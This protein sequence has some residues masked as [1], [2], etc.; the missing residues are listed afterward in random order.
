MEINSSINILGSIKDLELVIHFLIGSIEGDV[1]FKGSQPYT[2]VKTTQSFNR[3]GRVIRGVLLKSR[4]SEIELLL[5]TMLR[6]ESISLDSQLFLF[7]NSAINDDLLNY[8]NAKVFFPAFYSGRLVLR[9]DEVAACI[10]ELRETEEVIRGWSA[11]TLETVAGKYLTLLKKFNLLEGTLN[12][13]ILHPYLSD[14]MFVLFLY[15]LRANEAKSNILESEWLKYSFCE[16]PVFLERVMRKKFA[17][18]YEF[19]YT[20]DQLK[21][22]PLIPYKDIYHACK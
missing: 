16:Q 6:N 10:K 5:G 21:I 7:W 14:K 9:A 19:T 3:Y 18:F 17:D 20:V 22:D 4:K 15:W 8:L 1:L 13:K 12:K 11:N 2:S